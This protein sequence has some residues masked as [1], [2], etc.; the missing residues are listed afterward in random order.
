[1]LE[2]AS[3]S[4]TVPDSVDVVF[5][6]SGARSLVTDHGYVLAEAVERALPW[7]AAEPRAGIHPIRG[8]INEHGRLWLSRRSRLVLRLP[9]S[10]V[11][12]AKRVIGSR[13][14]VGDT[15]L[16]V[17][18][19]T[20]R[21]LMA[22]VSVYA[23]RVASDAWPNELA[24]VAA[25]KAELQ[26]RGVSGGLLCGREDRIR[27]TTGYMQVRSVLINGLDAMQ[28]LWLQATGLGI[29]RRLGC[30]LFVPYK[31]VEGI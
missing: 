28:S 15:E 27:A 22:H 2:S 23:Y 4:A 12:D 1:M 3:A 31:R 7:L 29:E 14:T 5:S 19:C 24:F 11:E 26:A 17:G 25:M 6:L 8:T 9:R 13:L 10:R 30:G 20:I 18:E 21:D 16:S